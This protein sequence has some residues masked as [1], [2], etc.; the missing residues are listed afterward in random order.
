MIGILK[1][2]KIWESTYMQHVSAKVF[3]PK[4]QRH[5]L[6]NLGRRGIYSRLLCHLQNFWEGWRTRLGKGRTQEGWAATRTAEIHGTKEY[7][8]TWA[9]PLNTW[10]P[11]LDRLICSWK[12]GS[13]DITHQNGL[14]S[15]HLL[16]IDL[17]ESGLQL[18]P[19]L[20]FTSPPASSCNPHFL[21]VSLLSI[22]PP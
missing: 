2:V 11:Q 20:S 16:G 18:I 10:L 14:S 22:L 15:F 7:V 13:V 3:T 9:P 4:Q 6:A 17:A 21:T 8:E 5:T 12:V 19:R 1:G